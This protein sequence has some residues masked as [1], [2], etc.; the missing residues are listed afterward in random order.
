MAF[1]PPNPGATHLICERQNAQENDGSDFQSHAPKL[2]E[3]E[4]S[5]IRAL[6]AAVMASTL[7]VG[8]LSSCEAGDGLMGG[9]NQMYT[10]MLTFRGATNIDGGVTYLREEALPI[11]TAQQGFRGVSASGNRSDNVFG[12]LSLWESEEAREASDSALGK[13]RKEAAEVVGGSLTVE[14]F[15]EMV[16]EV[17]KPIEPGCQLFITRVSMDPATLDQNLAFFKSD[18]LQMIKAEPGFC[19]LRNMGDRAAGKGVVGSIWESTQ[20][21]EAFVAKQPERRQTAEA[22]GV[23]FDEQETREILFAEIR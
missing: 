2:E 12:I 17:V 10:R 3:S 15:E 18:I 13:A 19:A 4:I 7:D 22:R 21:L 8:P 16:V 1:L 5:S 14:N 11:L 9:G 23:R 20:A 6:S